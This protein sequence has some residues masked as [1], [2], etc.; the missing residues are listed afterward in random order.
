MSESAIAREAFDV[1][2]RAPEATRNMM[3]TMQQGWQQ[4]RVDDLDDLDDAPGHGN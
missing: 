1:E 3:M 2:Q 4:G